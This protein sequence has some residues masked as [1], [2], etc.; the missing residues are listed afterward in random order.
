LQ[1]SLSTAEAEVDLLRRRLDQQQLN[2]SS[3]VEPSPT[4]DKP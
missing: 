2:N 1:A 3:R 4:P